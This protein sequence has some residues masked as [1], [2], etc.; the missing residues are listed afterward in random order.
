MSIASYVSEKTVARMFKA[1]FP[2]WHIKTYVGH[3]GMSDVWR[4][5]SPG[6]PDAILKVTDI[7]TLSNQR[8]GYLDECRRI[9]VREAILLDRLRPN[10]WI[11][12]LVGYA[13]AT[14]EGQITNRRN[15]TVRYVLI[16]EEELVPLRRYLEDAVVNEALLRQLMGDLC[17]GLDG[18][19][20]F[21]C[22]HRDLRIGNIYYRPQDHFFV[23]ADLGVT[24]MENTGTGTTFRPDSIRSLA[25]ELY[26]PSL[27]KGWRG[28][29]PFSSDL[30]SLGKLV[31]FLSRTYHVH[32]SSQ[33]RQLT[34]DLTVYDWK[35]RPYQSAA[36]LQKT[37]SN[38]D[39][40]TGQAPA[41][42]RDQVLHAIRQKN[43]SRACRLLE[44]QGQSWQPLYQYLR[45]LQGQP[46]DLLP[47]TLAGSALVN[48]LSYATQSGTVPQPALLQQAAE[49]SSSELLRGACLY[50]AG[51][52]ALQY[53]RLTPGSQSME[54][55]AIRLLQQAS[56]CQFSPAFLALQAGCDPI[57]HKNA[58]HLY[59][60]IALL[61]PI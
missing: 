38:L 30:Y 15:P 23:I 27:L 26:N 43:L 9:A 20:S 13:L 36:Q 50:Y 10:R 1:A 22:C 12:N 48:I 40:K 14:N 51:W 58:R 52:Y 46:V 31:E 3:G 56:A 19:H 39:G 5:A 37:L 49:T 17:R 53:S 55:S 2:Q 35:K 45:L 11:V 33:L 25:P 7:H 6:Q 54:H 29:P 34:A 16:V 44:G 41:L 18:I 4:V 24:S 8:R 57:Q 21:R 28:S 32:L 61:P 60:A 42:L 59:T 47:E